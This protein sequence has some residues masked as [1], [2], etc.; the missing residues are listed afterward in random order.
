LSAGGPIPPRADQAT[1]YTIVWNTQDEGSAVAGGTVSTVLPSYVSYTGLTA[2]TGS[3]LY[4]KGSRTVSW[5]T[6]NLA[7]G[8]GTYG[9]FQ[10]SLTPST[11]QT[12]TAPILTGTASFSG[13]DRFAGVR[14][15]ATAVPVTTE[16]VG[17]P[18]YVGTNAIVQ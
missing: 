4:D 2:G 17:D 15:S 18:G 11:S 8:A 12:G 3:F 9:A 1:T 16:T 10:V 6:G 14:V 5:S 13:Y 7:Q